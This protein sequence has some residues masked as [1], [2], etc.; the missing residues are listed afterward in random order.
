MGGL[1]LAFLTGILFGGMIMWF[2]GDINIARKTPDPGFQKEIDRMDQLLKND[3][4][5]GGK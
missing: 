4:T 3:K 2:F 1:I 5:T